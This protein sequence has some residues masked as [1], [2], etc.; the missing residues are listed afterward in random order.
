MGLPGMWRSNFLYFLLQVQQKENDMNSR[1]HAVLQVLLWVIC[2]FNV[3]IGL[4][5]NISQ[6]FPQAVAAFYGAQVEWTPAFMYKKSWIDSFSPG[7]LGYLS[8][9]CR[10]KS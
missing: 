1:L 5:L 9:M 7:V 10:K 6:D 3:I 2:A 4:G 8:S